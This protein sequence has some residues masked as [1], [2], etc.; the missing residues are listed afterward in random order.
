MG[1]NFL[2][3]QIFYYLHLELFQIFELFELFELFQQFSYF[4][5]F[6]IIL[7]FRLPSSLLFVECVYVVTILAKY[8]WGRVYLETSPNITFTDKLN[9]TRHAHTIQQHKQV[10]LHMQKYSRISDGAPQTNMEKLS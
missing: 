7:P 6:P 1:I 9:Y 2:D 3:L 4:N 8:L 5:H 10:I